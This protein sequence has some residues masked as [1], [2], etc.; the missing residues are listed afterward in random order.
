[1]ELRGCP[2]VN[3]IV[4]ATFNPGTNFAQTGPCV[5]SPVEAPV[6][7]QSVSAAAWLRSDCAHCRPSQRLLQ[8][9]GASAPSACA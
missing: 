9:N 6:W 8:V 1:M 4:K 3:Y 7:L 5:P 2:P